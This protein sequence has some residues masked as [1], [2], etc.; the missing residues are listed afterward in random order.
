MVSIGEVQTKLAEYKDLLTFEIIMVP[1]KGEHVKVQAKEYMYGEKGKET[2]I[3]INTVIK[4][5]GGEW[6]SLGRESHWRIPV[7]GT[8]QKPTVDVVSRIDG[9][10]DELKRLRNELGGN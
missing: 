5:L 2:W 9:I 4:D 7:E 10:I 6:V 1:G 8:P 3:E